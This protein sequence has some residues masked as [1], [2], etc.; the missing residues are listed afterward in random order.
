M[1]VLL[2][3]LS[4]AMLLAMMLLEI[5]SLVVVLFVV[6]LYIACGVTWMQLKR[7]NILSQTVEVLQN[8]AISCM[9]HLWCCSL[10]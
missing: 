9:C 4:L 8:W 5:V 1:M 6:L 7:A 2:V 3:V 10:W